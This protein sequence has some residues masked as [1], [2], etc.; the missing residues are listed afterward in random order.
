[1]SWRLEPRILR[2]PAG[3]DDGVDASLGVTLEAQLQAQGKLIEQRTKVNKLEQERLELL[4]DQFEATQKQLTI[5][6]DRIRQAQNLKEKLA[7]EKL[8]AEERLVLLNRFNEINGKACANDSVN[9]KDRG[10]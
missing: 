3:D 10:I 1:M 6:E 4:N 7:D 5:T 9:Q 8:K 2:M